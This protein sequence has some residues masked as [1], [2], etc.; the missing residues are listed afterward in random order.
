MK[1]PKI[2]QGGQNEPR[3]TQSPGQA[4]PVPS[5]PS[6]PSEKALGDISEVWKNGRPYKYSNLEEIESLIDT[7]F[8]E[9]ESTGRRPNVSDLSLALHTSYKGLLRW[10]ALELSDDEPEAVRAFKSGL[11][12]MISRAKTRCASAWWANLED[13]DKARGAEF[14]LKVMGYQD[15]PDYQGAQGTVTINQNNLVIGSSAE[16]AGLLAGI[17]P[18]PIARAQEES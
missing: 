18:K 11:R 2:P 5:L 1:T 3:R 16:V 9:C 12:Q 13:R 4:F 14:A 8:L 7:Y 10:E 6:Q 17:L 15:R